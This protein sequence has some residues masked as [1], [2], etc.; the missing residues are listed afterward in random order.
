MKICLNKDCPLKEQPQ[1]LSAFYTLKSATDGHTKQCKECIK[2]YQ[3][4][5]YKPRIYDAV[6]QKT[7]V[8]SYVAEDPDYFRRKHYQEY[9][10]SGE[11]LSVAL[12]KTANCQVCGAKDK[13][14]VDHCHETEKFRGFLCHNCNVA[15][16]MMKENP[17]NIA[18][19]SLYAEG[20]QADKFIYSPDFT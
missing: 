1:S 11:L 19:L 2:A 6:R 14:V 3:R 12:E 13:I 17:Q 16:G 8:K 15:L 9:G 18:K 4:A 10:L 7:Y 20:C 5:H